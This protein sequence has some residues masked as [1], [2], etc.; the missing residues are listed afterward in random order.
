MSDFAKFQAAVASRFQAMVADGGLYRVNVERDALW[1]TYLGSFPEGSNPLFRKRTEH[2]CSCCRGFIKSAGGVVSIGADGTISTLWDIYDDLR[3]QPAYQAVASAMAEL[4]RS[5]VIRDAFLHYE[6]R[7]GTPKNYEDKDGVVRAWDHFYVDI[8][9]GRNSGPNYLAIKRDIPTKLSELRQTRDVMVRGL[10]ELTVDA[11]DTALELIAS[12]SVARGEEFV[13]AIKAFRKLK[14]D[15]D[16]LPQADRDAFVWQKMST[17]PFSVARILNTAI[18]TF[19]AELSAD[20]DLEKAVDNFGKKMDP[21]NYRRPKSL[22]TQKMVEQAR[23][24]IDG[25]GLTSALGRRHAVLSDIRINDILFAD[26]SARASMKGDS[27]FDGVAN[28]ASSRAFDRVE[29]IG[30]VDFLRDIVPKVETIEVMVENKHRGNMVSLIAPAD[31]T[32]KRLFKWDNGFSWAYEGDVAD[33]IKERVKKAGGNVTGDL[34]CRLSWFNYDDLD[35]HLDFPGGHIYYGNKRQ[36]IAGGMLDVDMNPG[37]GG[38]GRGARTPVENIFF[39]DR[40]KMPEGGYRL[41]VNQYARVE[42]HDVGFEVEIDFM[43]DVCSFA[44]PKAVVGTVPVAYFHYS[45]AKGIEYESSLDSRAV[46]KETWGL[47]TQE[48][49]RVNVL[50]RSPN[51]WEGAQGV[52]NEHYF[53][54]LDGCRNDGDARGFF[55]EFLLPDLDKHR[56]VL[57]IVG[58]KTKVPPADEQ[59]SGL[60]FSTTKRAEVIVR[61]KGSVSRTFK[62]AI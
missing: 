41:S 25:L 50:M 62:V 34:C 8:P 47:K 60:G 42:S 46:S 37:G 28:K 38:Q 12:K 55:N 35:L 21:A 1:D 54:M 20:V 43:G 26:R 6:P 23:E 10:L 36:L 13:H 39:A 57:E 61:V 17:V 32:A 52:G 19:L 45:R 31:P 53:F 48:F 9:R 30:I 58:S 4:V 11:I 59:L 27:P 14:V 33:S 5:Q 16:K 29:K 40:F 22:V 7:I 51:H 49:H 24:T 3:G 2:D 56:K 18:G 15:F 44:Y